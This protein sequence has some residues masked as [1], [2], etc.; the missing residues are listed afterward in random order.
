MALDS[1]ERGM[2]PLCKC[3]SH[4]DVKDSR[5]STLAD[6]TP[7]IRRRRVCA[8]CGERWTTYEVHADALE[9]MQM[10]ARRVVAARIMRIIADEMERP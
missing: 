5:G 2:R 7:T 9:Q 1:R 10:D 6:G 8:S 3:G 4:A